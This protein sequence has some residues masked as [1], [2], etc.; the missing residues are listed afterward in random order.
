MYAI[1]A[2]PNRRVRSALHLH[3]GGSLPRIDLTCT[4]APMIG[5]W[6]QLPRQPGFYIRCFY[7]R[8]CSGAPRKEPPSCRRAIGGWNAQITRLVGSPHRLLRCKV[9][10]GYSSPAQKAHCAMLSRC[11]SPSHPV[12]VGGHDLVAPPEVRHLQRKVLARLHVIDRMQMSYTLR[13]DML[14]RRLQPQPS[15]QTMDPTA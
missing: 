6:P 8:S 12:A 14:T 5:D 7:I 2:S 4:S 3:H 13:L 9:Y 10:H 11:S 15:W 1:T